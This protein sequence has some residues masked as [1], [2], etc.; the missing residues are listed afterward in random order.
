[1]LHIIQK[2]DN[3]KLHTFNG[4]IVALEDNKYT[5][6]VQDITKATLINV[7]RNSD[8]KGSP[9][10]ISVKAI[11]AHGAITNDI[12]PFD[13]HLYSPRE[14]P[15]V[16]VIDGRL[17]LS[18][19]NVIFGNNTKSIKTVNVLYSIMNT[20]LNNHEPVQQD[21]H[22]PLYN[23]ATDK[24]E[25]NWLF[26]GYRD[27]VYIIYSLQPLVIVDISTLKEVKRQYWDYVAIP[28]NRVGCEIPFPHCQ[29]ELASSVVG[30]KAISHPS[31]PVKEEQHT[32][33][34]F[35]YNM[36]WYD[37]L[38]QPITEKSFCIRGGAPPVLYDNKY[39][40]FAHTREM[41]EARYRMV[42]IVLDE[43]LHVYAYTSPLTIGSYK[44]VYPAGAVF[45]LKSKTWYVSCGVEDKEQILFQIPHEFLLSKL[46]YIDIL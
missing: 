24:W 39:Y 34:K 22:I 2:T 9:C 29:P 23:N 15:R 32:L 33:P 6:I 35:K 12:E 31:L 18:Y 42:I 46:N 37:V 27:K 40:L 7:Y 20:L 17:Y 10:N 11:D 36:R 13:I 4:T 14:D 3:C 38:T 45:C 28:V 19:N 44:I 5:N 30:A 21:I 41:P 43:N 8:T 16:S 1:M 26:F 25:K